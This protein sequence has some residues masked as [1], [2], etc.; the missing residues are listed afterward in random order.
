MELEEQV[1]ERGEESSVG[2]R[3]S[4]LNVR[5]E[6][7]RRELEVGGCRNSELSFQL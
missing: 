6:E 2:K 7:G 4:F 5:L 3:S 1:V